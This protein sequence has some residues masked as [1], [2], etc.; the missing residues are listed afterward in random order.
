[1]AR[2]W[3]STGAWPSR[4]A[5]P[6]RRPGE[7][8]IVPVVLRLVR[9]AAGQRAGHAGLHEPRA[10]A[11]RAGP[12]GP[13]VGRLQPGR[14]PLLPAD[15]AGRRSRGKT[16]GPSSTPCRRATSRG[17]RRLDPSIDPALEAVC[18]QGDGTAARGSLRLAAVAGRGHRAVDGR[19]AGLGLGRA[20]L[21]AG[22]VARH[23][24][25]ARRNRHRG[26]AGCG[27]GRWSAGAGRGCPA[28][29]ASRRQQPDAANAEL[30]RSRAAV[31]ARYDLAVEAIKT[32]HTGVSED[33]L[34]KEDRS[35]RSCAT[36]S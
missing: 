32:F 30:D 28:V 26:V 3:S 33:F 12:V 25:G 17:R 34:L 11:R 27:R 1:M 6:T 7:R 4:W 5:G 9:D 15:R 23:R 14:D 36:G 18:L 13:A 19:R 31:Q 35:S 24:T 10:G 29:S 22:A 16:S 21:A 20:A 8:T 2:R